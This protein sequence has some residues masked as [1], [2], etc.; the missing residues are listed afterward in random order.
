M[1]RAASTTFAAASLLAFLA[2]CD[3]AAPGGG[4]SPADCVREMAG[5]AREGRA[6]EY[7][8]CF[9]G[10][11][12]QELAQ[13]RA[14]SGPAA[15]A[16]TLR[17]RAATV[18]GIAIYEEETQDADSTQLRVEWVFDGIAGIQPHHLLGFA[19]CFR[20]TFRFHQGF[21]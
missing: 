10:T 6:E 17:K 11:L 16:E 13:A 15:F 2:G 3:A 4:A 1:R 14:Q 8:A 5:H 18:R 12:R 9:A 20:F 21:R 19:F 7:L